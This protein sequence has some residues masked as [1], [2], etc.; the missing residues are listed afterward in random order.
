[1][2]VSSSYL[3]QHYTI[4]SDSLPWVEMMSSRRKLWVSHDIEIIKDKSQNIGL[5]FRE[6]SSMLLVYKLFQLYEELAR[7]EPK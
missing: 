4:L 5:T 2:V 1:M 7:A 3:Y 6:V